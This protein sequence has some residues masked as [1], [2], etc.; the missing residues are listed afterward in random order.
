MKVSTH[1][2]EGTRGL[3]GLVSA[4]SLLD[5]SAEC[6]MVAISPNRNHLR[7]AGP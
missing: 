3:T 5:A 1:S 7:M 4:F 6:T 2:R